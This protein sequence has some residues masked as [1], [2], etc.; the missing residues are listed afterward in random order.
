VTWLLRN[1]LLD[2]EIFSTLQEAQVLIERRR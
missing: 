1:K 2:R